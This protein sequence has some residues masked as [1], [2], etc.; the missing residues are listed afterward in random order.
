M[1]G[2]SKNYFLLPHGL[3]I[4]MQNQEFRRFSQEK[5]NLPPAG[6]LEPIIADEGY[7]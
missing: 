6:R 1:E 3:S 7:T 2:K 4:M 5:A